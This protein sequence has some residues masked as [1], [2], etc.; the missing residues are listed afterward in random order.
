MKKQ[1]NMTP[2]KVHNYSTAESKD[3]EMIKL[4]DKEIKSLVLKMIN[5]LKESSNEHMNEVMK[6][7]QD[8][9]EKFSKERNSEKMEMKSSINQIQN[10]TETPPID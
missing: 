7:I 3:T 9:N 5:D 4:Q 2:L 1:D 6:S 8:M 10:T